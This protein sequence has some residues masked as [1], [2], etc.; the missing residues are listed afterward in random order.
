MRED[1]LVLQPTDIS[2]SKGG[3]IVDT[4]RRVPMYSRYGIS[5]QTY[6]DTQPDEH[7]AFRVVQDLRGEALRTVFSTKTASATRRKSSEC[8]RVDEVSIGQT[9]IICRASVGTKRWLLKNVKYPIPG[10]KYSKPAIAY[11][12][13]SILHSYRK[14]PLC[15]C[16]RTVRVFRDGQPSMYAHT[17]RVILIQFSRAHL[18]HVY[19]RQADLRLL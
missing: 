4:A 11:V 3:N 2:R 12:G 5:R 6:L 14:G 17:F 9:R 1:G 10:A 7:R 13:A 19:H 16:C 15:S 8:C 18:T